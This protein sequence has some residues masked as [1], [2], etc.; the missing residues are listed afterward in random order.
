M[1]NIKAG[2]RSKLHTLGGYSTRPHKQ[3][4]GLKHDS[5]YQDSGRRSYRALSLFARLGS[6]REVCIE[7]IA[8]KIIQALGSIMA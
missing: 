4:V 2:T 8:S 1:E 6:P 3:R 5:F 7:A